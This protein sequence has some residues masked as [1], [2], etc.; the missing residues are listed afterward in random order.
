VIYVTPVWLLIGVLGIVRNLCVELDGR[1]LV[2][3]KKAIDS[4]ET[5]KVAFPRGWMHKIK[6]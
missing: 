1:L 4:L 5:I 6:P 2:V 3:T